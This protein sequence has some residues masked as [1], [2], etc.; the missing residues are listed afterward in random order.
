MFRG[1]YGKLSF[2]E[3]MWYCQAVRAY[4]ENSFR[5][6]GGRYPLHI[7]FV[8]NTYNDVPKSRH[9]HSSSEKYTGLKRRAKLKYIRFCYQFFSQ[10]SEDLNVLFWNKINF[11][12]PIYTLSKHCLERFMRKKMKKN[13]DML[14]WKRYEHLI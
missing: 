3:G 9:F 4:A 8:S 6:E 7:M 14:R 2:T 10:V 13:T 11:K 5:K 12:Q 1:P